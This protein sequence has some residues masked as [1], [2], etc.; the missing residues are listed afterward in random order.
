M[1]SGVDLR[2]FG[3]KGF[4]RDKAEEKGWESQRERGSQKQG[5]GGTSASHC[6]S[7]AA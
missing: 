2:P 3:L 1:R 7:N 6:Y 4:D 5:K